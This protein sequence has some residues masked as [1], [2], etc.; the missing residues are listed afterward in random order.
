MFVN[1]LTIPGFKPPNEY[2]LDRDVCDVAKKESR[3]NENFPPARNYARRED[4][5][6]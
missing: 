1:V 6:D 3:H 2:Y 4:L 5:L